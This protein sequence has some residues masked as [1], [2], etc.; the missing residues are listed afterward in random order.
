MVRNIGPVNDYEAHSAVIPFVC[1]IIPK[2]YELRQQ[3]H[4]ILL[5]CVLRQTKQANFAVYSSKPVPVLFFIVGPTS[6]ADV[7]RNLFSTS[8]GPGYLAHQG[9]WLPWPP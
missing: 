3:C 9:P 4:F 7:S 6:F 2:Q 8:N 5:I 1:I